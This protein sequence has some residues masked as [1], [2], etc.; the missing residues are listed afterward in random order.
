MGRSSRLFDIIQIL[1]RATAPVTAR[2]I[3]DALEVSK[4]TIYRDVITLQA[5]RVPIE[6]EAG[7]GYVMQAGFDLPPLMFTA[8][9]IEAIVVGLSLL[10]RT[11][12]ADLLAAASRVSRKIADV[13]PDAADSR[14]EGSPLHVSHW[15]EVP[16]A[17]VEYRV[18]RQAIREERKLHLHYQDAEARSTERTVRPIAL[19]YYVDN[20]LLAAWCEMR[21]DFR[22][23]R[24]DRMTACQ[25]IDSVFK[26]ESDLLR[27]KW[28][29]RHEL[30]S[31]F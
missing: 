7:V 6:G 28:R 22:H 17:M 14:I 15:N 11:G 24:V 12:D 10:G 4:R 1:R 27:T 31:A 20:V 26:G 29:E 18:I 25:L 13:L 19:V 8:D 23:F 3:A 5:M 9:E 21:D 2:A 30:F 16:P